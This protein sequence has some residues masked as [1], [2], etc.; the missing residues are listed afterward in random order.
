[1]HAVQDGVKESCVIALSESAEDPAQ[2]QK[3]SNKDQEIR[4]YNYYRSNEHC[5]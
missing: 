3:Y 5:R 4:A 2:E 1:M